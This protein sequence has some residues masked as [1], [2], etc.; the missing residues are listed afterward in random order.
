MAVQAKEEFI[1]RPAQMEDLENAVALM[2][3]CSM[4]SVG[5]E[6]FDVTEIRAEW[7]S[8]G[9][10]LEHSTRMALTADGDIVG[11]IEV[12]DVNPV[13]V[14]VWV[15]GRVHPDYE[16]QGIGTRLMEWAEGRAREAIERVPA[17]AQVIMESGTISTHSPSHALFKDLGMELT[18][19]F[20]TMRIDM[21]SPP[22]APQW[23]E[24]ITVRTL[25]RGEDD[26]AAIFATDD[27]FKDHWGHVDQPVEALLER[28]Q[29][30]MDHDESF[31]ASL[32]FLAMGGDEIA[33]ISFCWPKANN[34]PNV[35]Y[36]GTLGVRRPW[37]KQGLGLALVLHSFAEFWE[38][39][40]RSVE[41]GVDASSL[42]G[43]T[44]LYE[45]AGM[46]VHRQFDNYRKVLRPGKDLT[47][48]SL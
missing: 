33:G 12:W 14:R 40:I 46:H 8:P 16:G 29:H 15:W 24:G 5:Q 19:H 21:D 1:I 25:V 18:R 34:D 22:P 20:Y 47:T 23:P 9:F 3:I 17:D 41:L 31:D 39:G 43:A 2:N 37:R 10:D 30:F 28:W 6:E 45:R 38:R 44:R 4:A 48:H 27:A 11:Y 42:T 7:M 35:G 32:W 36:V 13:P 26:E